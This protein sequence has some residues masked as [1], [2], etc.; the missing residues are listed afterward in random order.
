MRRVGESERR[1]EAGETWCQE[2]FLRVQ[3][4]N[5]RCE[6]DVREEEVLK[7]IINEVL[8][9]YTSMCPFL[10]RISISFITFSKGSNDP[11][12]LRN[13]DMSHIKCSDL[14][15]LLLGV[16]ACPQ[17]YCNTNGKVFSIQKNKKIRTY[18]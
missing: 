13:I 3:M 8:W 18:L 10:R 9:G 5:C 4:R 6:T 16:T 12:I 15:E 7:G 14:R 11:K 2:D 17:K 1:R